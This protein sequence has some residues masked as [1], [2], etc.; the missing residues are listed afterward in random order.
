MEP[1]HSF[2]AGFLLAITEGTEGQLKGNKLG[3][4]YNQLSV[5]IFINDVGLC[6]LFFNEKCFFN[7]KCL[8][9]FL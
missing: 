4:G 3:H 1:T 7:D 9:T 6:V 5:H 2:P 8:Y